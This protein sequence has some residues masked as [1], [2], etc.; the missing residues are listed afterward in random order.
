MCMVR[1]IKLFAYVSYQVGCPVW[2]HTSSLKKYTLCLQLVYHLS[3][4]IC[5]FPIQ[6]FNMFFSILSFRDVFRMNWIF[7][8]CHYLMVVRL[9]LTVEMAFYTK[10]RVRL[11]VLDRIT[12]WPILGLYTKRELSQALGTHYFVSID[13]SYHDTS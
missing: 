8:F 4:S 11:H 6:A 9:M 1:S 7:L 12:I 5:Q 2:Y 10:C 3:T 13:V